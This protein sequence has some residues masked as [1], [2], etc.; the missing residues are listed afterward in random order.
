MITSSLNPITDFHD[1]F[2]HFTMIGSVSGFLSRQANYPIISRGKTTSLS[3]ITAADLDGSSEVQA[4]RVVGAPVEKGY[5]FRTKN[6]R[7]SWWMIDP[8]GINETTDIYIYNRNDKPGSTQ[9]A[10]PLDI[11]LPND[12]LNWTLMHPGESDR[13]FGDNSRPEMLRWYPRPSVAGRFVRLIVRR[14]TTLHLCHVGIRG[15]MVPA[16]DAD[17]SFRFLYTTRRAAS[18]QHMDEQCTTGTI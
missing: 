18:A 5:S 3:S 14:T 15:R 2:D 16:V 10:T 1:A 6:A 17:L 7:E 4:A 13:P 11:D 9:D 8:G 12:G